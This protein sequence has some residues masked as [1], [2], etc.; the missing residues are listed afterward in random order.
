MKKLLLTG[1]ACALLSGCAVYE[2][3][4]QE[5]EKPRFDST[6]DRFTGAKKA[7]WMKMYY[8]DHYQKNLPFDKLF[9]VSEVK[10]EKT[11]LNMIS[12]SREFTDWNY[13]KC[14][15]TAWLVDG[16][17]IKPI[18]NK[19]NPKTLIHPVRVKEEIDVLFSNAD[20]KKFSK[21]KKVEYKVCN[22]E[23]ILTEEE[24]SG[25]KQVIN[26]IYK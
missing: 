25:L 11:N 9:A 26:E 19:M 18:T 13:L 24:L 20:M 2:Q 22:D 5:I 14:H 8:G 1:L 12:I 10:K 16:K 15:N 4:K 21:A 23:F 17:P 7:S 3:N 6:V